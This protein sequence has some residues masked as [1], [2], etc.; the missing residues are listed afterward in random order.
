MKKTERKEILFDCLLSMTIST[1]TKQN[2]RE[3]KKSSHTK[4]DIKN[5]NTL[6]KSKNIY[7]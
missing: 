4:S 7:G 2:T 1:T 3:C 5:T 6:K